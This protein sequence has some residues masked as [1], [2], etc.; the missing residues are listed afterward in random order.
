MKKILT[1]P[2][3]QTVFLLIISVAQTVVLILCGPISVG[4][5][6]TKQFADIVCILEIRFA[7]RLAYLGNRAHSRW[8]R[9]ETSADYD[10]PSDRAVAFTKLFG[11]IFLFGLQIFMF[12]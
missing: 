11:Y 6:V 9:K 3:A 10:E 5:I 12:V 8:H 4:A 1:S 2:N 7:Y